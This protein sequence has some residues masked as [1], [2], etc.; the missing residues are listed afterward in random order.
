VQQSNILDYGVPRMHDIPE[1]H[2]KLMSTP[3][4]P[5]GAGQMA[6]PIV[7]PAI[8]S[9]VF[10]GKRRALAH[11]PFLPGPARR[12]GLSARSGRG[13]VSPPRAPDRFVR[14]SR[15]SARAY[16]GHVDHLAV[17]R[18]RGA[19]SAAAFRVPLDHA[20]RVRDFF[21]GR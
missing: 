5:T 20:L 3:N 17:D 10:R 7:A 19:P 8:S 2:V 13:S 4:R 16:D 15:R 9:A 18:E 12:D 6:T 14:A 11:M 1:L 21:W